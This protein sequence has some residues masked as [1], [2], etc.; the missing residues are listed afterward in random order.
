M[1]KDGHPVRRTKLFNVNQF[2]V[3]ASYDMSRNLHEADPTAACCQ[4]IDAALRMQIK[5]TT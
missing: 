3:R 4:T 1:H 2:A 5:S